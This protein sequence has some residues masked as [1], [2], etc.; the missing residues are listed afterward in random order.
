MLWQDNLTFSS[1]RAGERESPQVKYY[2]CIHEDLS[3]TPRA[4]TLKSQVWLL[5]Y[6]TPGLGMWRE[7]DP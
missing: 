5:M 4:Q 6:V 3:L 7:G 2:L 1:G